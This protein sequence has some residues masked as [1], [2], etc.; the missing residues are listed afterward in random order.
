MGWTDPNPGAA[1]LLE[2]ALLQ[3]GGEFH[4]V[5][6]AT[7]L[8]VRL[9]VEHL[10]RVGAEAYAVPAHTSIVDTR[11]GRWMITGLPMVLRTGE[12]KTGGGG[13]STSVI[14]TLDP[15][16][17]FGMA[18]RPEHPAV[19]ATGVMAAM[20]RGPWLRVRLLQPG[21]HG[22]AALA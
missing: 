12:S 2:T 20:Q 5:Q 18:W 15:Y 3:G 6:G 4:A 13:F 16:L 19:A 7:A 1:A 17:G 22:N 9:R 8:D 11:R 14:A 21:Q 10:W